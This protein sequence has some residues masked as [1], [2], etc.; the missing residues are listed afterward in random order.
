MNVFG[1]VPIPLC[2]DLHRFEYLG[3]EEIEVMNFKKIDI[4]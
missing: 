4:T 3:F 2:T 1:T